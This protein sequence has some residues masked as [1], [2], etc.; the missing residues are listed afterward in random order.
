MSQRRRPPFVDP[1]AKQVYSRCATTSNLYQ[2]TSM[3]NRHILTR[4]VV[5][6][7]TGLALLSVQAQT[8][9]SGN[10]NADKSTGQAGDATRNG[11]PTTA[12]GL[13]PGAKS[14]TGNMGAVPASGAMSS[15]PNTGSTPGAIPAE[16]SPNGNKADTPKS[17]NK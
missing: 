1:S 6:A 9:S 4:V 12:P 5:A 2:E 14:V 3:I 10:N 15:N 17:G 11:S 8:G 13:P 7:A 16:R